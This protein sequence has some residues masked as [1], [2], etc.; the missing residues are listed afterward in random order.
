MD[1]YLAGDIDEGAYQSKSAQFRQDIALTEESLAKHEAT[2]LADRQAALRIFEW[3]Q[4][5]AQVWRGSNNGVKR[6]ILET[7]CLNRQLGDVSLYLPKSKPFDFFIE[8]PKI[9]NS[10]GD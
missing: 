8:G 6:E 4:N 2:T 9:K 1:V 10:R 5:A 3:T 7:V